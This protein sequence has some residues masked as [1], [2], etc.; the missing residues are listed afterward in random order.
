[1]TPQPHDSDPEDNG[2]QNPDHGASPS[3]DAPED[4][5]ANDAKASGTSG[6]TE[7]LIAEVE[8]SFST[9]DSEALASNDSTRSSAEESSEQLAAER[10][11]DLQRL[12]AEYVNYRKRVER[13]KEANRTIA[14]GSVLESLLPVL[15]DI[16]SAREHGDLKE[17]PF[18][19]IAD[20]LDE[21]LA[22]IGLERIDEKG[23]EF[24]PRI[25]EALLQTPDPQATTETVGQVLRPGYVFG[26]RVLRAAQVAVSVPQNS[27]S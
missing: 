16:T 22:K 9:D 20:K 5:G 11:A 26:E 14:I 15:D 13:D 2:A 8:N 23:A 1:M 18:A 17:G 27:N 21:T 4:A 25:H 3:G 12:Q 7:D 19:A 6:S 10:L 24:D